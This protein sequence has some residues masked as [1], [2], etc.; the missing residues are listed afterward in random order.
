MPTGGITATDDGAEHPAGV[1]ALEVVVLGTNARWPTPEHAV[2]ASLIMRGADHVLIDC[3]EGTQ[4]QLMRSVA[5]LRRLSVILITHCHADHVLGLPGLLATLSDARTAP[6]L[7]LGPV[8]VR[9]LVDGF[10]VHFGAL[11]F[12]LT[13]REVGPGA[14]ERRDGYRLLAVE[15]SH[16]IPAV[17]WALAEDPLPG[18]LI[19]ERLQRLGVPPGPARS[20]LARGDEVALADGRRVTPAQ[21]TGPPRPGRTIV[22]SGDTRP[23]AA[24]ADAAAGADLLMHEA[25]FLERDRDLAVRSGHSTAADAARLAAQARVGLLA[26]VHRSTRYAREEILAEARALYGATV[27]PEDLDL[28]EVPLAEHGPPRLRPQGGRAGP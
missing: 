1:P 11:S 9:A 6:L 15:A 18:H 17:A 19:E 13:I 5:G 22:L 23:A 25:T 27:A 21:V 2:S 24:V 12:P 14:V 8:G 16:R 4:R 28:I 7:L 10:R 20:A 26:L 3:G